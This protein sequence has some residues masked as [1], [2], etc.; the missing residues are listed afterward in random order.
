MCQL[1]LC[2]SKLVREGFRCH[3]AKPISITA[4]W[5][6]SL[7][8]LGGGVNLFKQHLLLSQEGEGLVFYFELNHLVSL[9]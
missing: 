7:L 5:G 9:T 1:V 3:P 6:V 2:F 4:G 8:R